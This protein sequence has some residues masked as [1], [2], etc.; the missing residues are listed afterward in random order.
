[1]EKTKS[2]FVR[3]VEAAALLGMGKTTVYELIQKKELPAVRLGG[4][5]R[6]PRAALEKLAA[7]AI[8]QSERDP[9]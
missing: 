7:D 3:P 9:R 4:A 2:L 1:M 6:I 5:L 8:R